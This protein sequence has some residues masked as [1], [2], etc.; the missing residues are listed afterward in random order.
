MGLTQKVASD[1][2][3]GWTRG[4]QTIFEESGIMHIPRLIPKQDENKLKIYVL[5]MQNDWSDD[6][7]LTIPAF[8]K[9]WTPHNKAIGGNTET[10]IW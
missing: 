2:G 5:K 3:G 1:Q 9:A 4:V 7:I 8:I 10:V 6:T